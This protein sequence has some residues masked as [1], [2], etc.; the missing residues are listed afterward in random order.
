MLKTFVV[1]DQTMTGNMVAG[2]LLSTIPGRY[3][4]Y[5]PEDPW[6][7]GEGL[8]VDDI[9]GF[10]FA[11]FRKRNGKNV[12]ELFEGREDFLPSILTIATAIS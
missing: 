2:E 9:T 7:N 3:C 1:N 6:Q 12:I 5:M 10:V 4:R 8:L 11:K